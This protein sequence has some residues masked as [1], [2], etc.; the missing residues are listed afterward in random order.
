MIELIITL[1]IGLINGLLLIYC[2]YLIYSFDSIKIKWYHLPLII[3]YA[4]GFTYSIYNFSSLLHIGTVLFG[5]IILHQVIFRKNFSTICAGVFYINIIR[6]ITLII[7][8]ILY[9]VFKITLNRDYYWISTL[10]ITILSFICIY[11][12]RN[13]MK[14]KIKE[15]DIY[16][17]K[18]IESIISIN[19]I[20]TIIYIFEISIDT[21]GISLVLLYPILALT[22]LFI[23]IYSFVR[24]KV[25]LDTYLKN[26]SEIAKFAC[27]M[28]NII[29]NYRCKLYETKNQLATVKTYIN[30]NNSKLIEY[31][32]SLIEEKSHIEYSWLSELNAFKTPGI[33]GFISYKIQE[34]KELGIEVELFISDSLEKINPI[35]TEQELKDLY[36]LI[37]VFCDESINMVNGSSEKII[38]VQ[39]FCQDNTIIIL[40]A[41]SYD[42]SPYQTKKKNTINLNQKNWYNTGLYIVSSII[43]NNDIFGRELEITDDFLIQKLLIKIK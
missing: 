7:D 13:K 39:A 30:K 14:D 15:Y 3:A 26:Y 33:K 16:N 28:E 24:Q 31:L 1:A 38:T 4:L 19:F 10:V 8:V 2:G 20:I 37:G 22:Y 34:M 36:V 25:K 17:L 11:I 41:N 35:L 27:F 23:S 40:L 21:T 42:L 18:S 43:E 12:L 5:N 29:V 32:N 9:K 6:I